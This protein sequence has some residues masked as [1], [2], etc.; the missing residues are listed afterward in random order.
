MPKS[1]ALN[2]L[3]KKEVVFLYEQ[4]IRLMVKKSQAFEAFILALTAFLSSKDQ[5]E[6]RPKNFPQEE[7]W[8]EV[9]K[10]D[11]IW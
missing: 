10:K 8:I 11:I 9:P 6:V 4:D 7:S 5:C 3:V 1:W 2:A